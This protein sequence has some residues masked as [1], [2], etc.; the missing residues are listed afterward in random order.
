MIIIYGGQK[1]EIIQVHFS[2]YGL[3][4]LR[5][6]ERGPKWANT[7]PAQYPLEDCYDS[8]VYGPNLSSGQIPTL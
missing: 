2:F 3:C 7:H 5:E 8:V 4:T 1:I 6:R